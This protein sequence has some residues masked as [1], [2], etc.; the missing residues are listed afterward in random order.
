MAKSEVER[1]TWSIPEVSS[2]L[3]V[4]ERTVWS[5]LRDDQLPGVVR[6]GAR[7]LVLRQALINA[8]MRGAGLDPDA[9]APSTGE[10]EA[11]K[12]T[13]KANAAAIEGRQAVAVARKDGWT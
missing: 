5:M 1:L 2:A 7:V 10:A 9:D 3:G 13:A 12:A 6:I 11:T 4:S 8:L